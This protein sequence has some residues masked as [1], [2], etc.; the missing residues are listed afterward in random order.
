M[1]MK[2]VVTF[3]WWLKPYIRVLACC[4]VLAGRMPDQAKLAA[5]VKRAT[6]ITIQ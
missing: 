5:K 4:C 2:L 3:A 6:R 1:Q